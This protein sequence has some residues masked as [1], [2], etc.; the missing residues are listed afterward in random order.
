MRPWKYPN[1]IDNGRY[2]M[3]LGFRLKSPQSLTILVKPKTKTICAITRDC[4]V[5]GS[6][7]AVAFHNA[8]GMKGSMT[9]ASEVKVAMCN[10]Y[11]H[12]G[13]WL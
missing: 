10:A 4:R 2:K 9:K 13:C 5:D 3:S 6:K 1:T 7:F 8:K 12:Q 11:V